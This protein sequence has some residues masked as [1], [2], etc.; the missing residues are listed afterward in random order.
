MS[1]TVGTTEFDKV[2]WWCCWRPR[3][4]S[5]LLD[6]RCRGPTSRTTIMLTMNTVTGRTTWNTTVSMW[7]IAWVVKCRAIYFDVS[8]VSA[9][10]ES[11]NNDRRSS[12]CAEHVC[13]HIHVYNTFSLLGY[14]RINSAIFQKKKSSSCNSCLTIPDM[15]RV[16]FR[17]LKKV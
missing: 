14:T 11:N 16:Y 13:L 6:A 17:P 7:L 8:T 12:L 4:T 9:S 5:A 10:S 15:T 2:D 1:M 3:L